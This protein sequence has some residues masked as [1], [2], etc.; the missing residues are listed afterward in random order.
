MNLLILFIK[1]LFI[2]TIAIMIAYIFIANVTI[3]VSSIFDA[4]IKS[5]CFAFILAPFS[6][7]SYFSP[8]IA[9]MAE[10][11]SS[12][13]INKPLE[14]TFKNAR[15]L[16]KS[17]IDIELVDSNSENNWINL[18]SEFSRVAITLKAESEDETLITIK[19][20]PKVYLNINDFDK[21][22]KD[23][24]NISGTIKL[25]LDSKTYETEDIYYRDNENNTVLEFKPC[26]I[27]YYRMI[28]AWIL[29]SISISFYFLMYYFALNILPE[30]STIFFFAVIFLF[31]LYL[32]TGEIEMIDQKI[33]CPSCNSRQIKNKYL[34]TNYVVPA[35]CHHCGKSLL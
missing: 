30:P 18:E 3:T 8:L 10:Y 26:L 27:L 35:K 6:L 12:F 31:M 16:L 32:F 1:R 15:T 22:I 25:N 14:D 19:S 21:Y 2:Y 11:N 5:I 24:I 34:I 9:K 28:K 29:A 4:F 13:I 17:M 33:V 20:I 23:V 7:F